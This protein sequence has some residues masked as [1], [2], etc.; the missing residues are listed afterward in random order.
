MKKLIQKNCYYYEFKGHY[1]FRKR[2]SKNVIKNASKDIIFRKSIL[3]ICSDY[4]TIKNKKDIIFNLTNYLNEQL[5]FYIKIKGLISI[6]EITLYIQDLC[7]KYLKEAI[8]EYSELEDLRNNDIQIIDSDKITEGHTLNAI[9]KEWLTINKI[10][11]NLTQ[12]SHIKP[13]S[14]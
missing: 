1:Y 11:K 8:V 12:L 9:A 3:K 7:E 13:N 6:E 2:L 4:K 5:N 14:F 10:T